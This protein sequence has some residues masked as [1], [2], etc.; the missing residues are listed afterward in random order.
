MWSIAYKSNLLFIT[1]F[2]TQLRLDRQCDLNQF[3]KPIQNIKYA[4]LKHCKQAKQTSHTRTWGITWRSMESFEYSQHSTI[5]TLWNQ[6]FSASFNTLIV[7]LCIWSTFAARWQIGKFILVPQSRLHIW[8][9]FAW[10]WHNLRTDTALLSIHLPTIYRFYGWF[11]H[12]HHH[13]Y[14]HHYNYDHNH[15]H[16]QD[17]RQ[18]YELKG[19]IKKSATRTGCALWRRMIHFVLCCSYTTI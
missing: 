8:W 16:H 10:S 3:F 6:T 11:H 4:L 5:G 13:E 1:I 7:P 18:H 2:S 14:H 15:Y 17:Q 12:K 19:K 9:E